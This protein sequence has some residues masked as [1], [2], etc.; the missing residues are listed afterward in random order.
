MALWDR[1]PVAYR[2][3]LDVAF[4]E[5]F[6]EFLEGYQGLLIPGSDCCG[7]N[8][9]WHEIKGLEGGKTYYYRLRTITSQGVSSINS[10]TASI[11]TKWP[12]VNHQAKN[13]IIT[14]TPL[15]ELA[16]EDIISNTTSENVQIHV[17]YFDGLGRPI[18]TVA[19]R[20]SPQYNDIVQPIAYDEFGRESIQYLPYASQDKDGYF[21]EAALPDHAAFYQDKF[22]DSKGYSKAVLE[23]SP[24][25]R[26]LKQGSPG[27][28]WQPNADPLNMNDHTVKRR[29]DYNGE[30]EV[31]LF[32]YNESSGLQNPVADGSLVYYARDQL[33]ANKTY[34]EHNKE[35]IEYTDKEGRTILKKVESGTG[36]QGNK[37]YAQTYYIYDK[38]GQL[39]I[40]L[41]PE[42]VAKFLLS[43]NQN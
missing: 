40:V 27:A 22:A 36:A 29:Y 38:Y 41:P 21:N 4:D 3:E 13:M 17:A 32:K 9:L 34:D 11:T 16:D 20:S 39:V 14:R 33:Y 18:Q 10:N 15:N 26:M 8:S 6:T 37:L 23:N 28:T 30:R 42:G 19:V 1:V 31:I 7:D 5:E 25:G 24:L 43:L 12:S 35:I 2:Y